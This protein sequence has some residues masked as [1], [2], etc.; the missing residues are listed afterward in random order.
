MSASGCSSVSASTV[1]TSGVVTLRERSVER[2]VLARL[3]LE[4]P[5]VVE[6]EPLG[7][8]L[9]A[10]SAV[11]SVELLSASTTSSGPG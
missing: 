3:G 11:R 10:R 2:V 7:G 5:P 1:T 9:G 8:R 4:D 6:A